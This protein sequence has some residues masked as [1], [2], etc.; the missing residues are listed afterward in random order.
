MLFDLT[1]PLGLG[2]E[3]TE[4]DAGY[5]SSAVAPPPPRVG[6]EKSDVQIS[7]LLP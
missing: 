5:H 1:V 7:L 2:E 3:E 4:V 6:P